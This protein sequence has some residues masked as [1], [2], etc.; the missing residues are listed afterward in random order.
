MGKFFGIDLAKNKKILQRF[1]EYLDFQG[2]S[3]DEAIRLLV[4]RFKLPGEA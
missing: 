3:L 1:C 2:L 4:S